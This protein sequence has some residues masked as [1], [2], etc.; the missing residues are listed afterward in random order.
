VYGCIEAS[1]FRAV[2]T[3][4]VANLHSADCRNRWVNLTYV[5]TVAWRFAGMATVL[6]LDVVEEYRLLLRDPSDRKSSARS[7]AGEIAGLAG[8]REGRS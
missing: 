2:R 7:G 4:C 8:S 6:K 3:D 5:L 1:I